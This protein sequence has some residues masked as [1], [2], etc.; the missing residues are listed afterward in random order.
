[1]NIIVKHMLYIY[2]L[3]SYIPEYNSNDKYLIHFH[4]RQINKSTKGK[5]ILRKIFIA[6]VKS[7]M[8]IFGSK[9]EQLIIQQV[10]FK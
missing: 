3:K 8:Y 10:I 1:M 2:N 7:P 5:R 9:Y 6:T 4:W